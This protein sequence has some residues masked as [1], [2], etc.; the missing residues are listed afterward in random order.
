MGR[1]PLTVFLEC[2]RFTISTNHDA[3]KWMLIIPK[4]TCKL[5]RWSLQLSEIDFEV[6]HRAGMK[7]QAACS[8]SRLATN[9]EDKSSHKNDIPLLAIDKHAAEITSTS[10]DKV[11]SLQLLQQTSLTEFLRAQASDAYCRR[12]HAHVDHNNSEFNGNTDGH[13]VRRLCVNRAVRIVVS[14]SIC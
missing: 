5:A 10:S 6:V 14:P 2:H 13:F 7:H 9:G 8:L 11:A 12:G 3:L 1:R 4:F